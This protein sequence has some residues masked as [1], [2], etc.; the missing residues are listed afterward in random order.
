[1]PSLDIAADGP[2]DSLAVLT[3]S[4]HIW[5]SLGQCHPFNFMVDMLKIESKLTTNKTIYWDLNNTCVQWV[6]LELGWR[7][8]RFESQAGKK[9]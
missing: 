3:C 1:M 7:G 2:S 4:S 8:A 9:H 5:I 6:V